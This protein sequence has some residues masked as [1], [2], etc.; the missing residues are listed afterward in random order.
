MMKLLQLPSR[1]FLRAV[2]L[3]ALLALICSGDYLTAQVLDSKGKEFWV[4]FM[5]NL[6]S[7]QGDPP[8]DLRFYLSADKPATVTITYTAT[9]VSQ[10]VTMPTANVSREVNINNLFGDYTEL[11]DVFA[12]AE[13][14]PKSYHIT[15][16]EEI[17]L[18]GINIL[19]K[20][21]DAFLGLPSDVL[22]GRYIV[23][24]YPNGWDN[25]SG[26]FDTPSQFC[27]IG[28]EDGTQ[29]R[30]TSPPGTRINRHAAATP[31]TV[32]L[33]RGQVFFGQASLNGEQ[34]VSGTEILADKPVAVFGGNKRTSIPTR[35]GNFRDHLVEQL[36]PLDAWGRSALVTPH[37][38]IT[39]GSQ[40]TAV[41]RI[42][43]AFLGTEVTITD[44]AGTSK[45]TL[46]PGN[47]IELPLM[48]PMSVDA[49]Q[50]IMVAQYEH[51][52]GTQGNLGDPFMMLVPPS[53]QF[54]TAYA[55]QSVLHSEFSNAHF[56]NVVIPSGGQ[57]S[58]ILDNRPL[59]G[60]FRPIPGSRHLYAQVR[61]SGGS[62]YIRA[63][64][65][66]GLYVYGYGEA[67]SY[68]YPGGMLFRTLV[69]DFQPPEISWEDTCG[70]V[71][72]VTFD[73]K[74]TDSGLDSVYTT[75]DTK[76]VN[77][78]IDPFEAGE[79][80][81]KY[82]AQLVDP[83][84]DGLI[85]IKAVDR[86]GRIRTQTNQIPGFTLRVAGVQNAPAV[87]D[88][89]VATN[90]Q[91]FCRQVSIRN[92]GQFEQELTGAVLAQSFPGATITTGF[93][94]KIPPGGVGNI[95]ICF[96]N[97][98]DTV[99]SVTLDISGLCVD[100]RVAIIPIDSRIDTTAPSV[101][102]DGRP[103]G[104]E[105][106][107]NY[108]EQGRASG[109]VSVE[110]D[111]LINCTAEMVTDTTAL[112][113][114]VLQLRLRR[115]N[116]RQDMIYAIR[117]RDAAGNTV[118]DR[119]TIGGFTVVVLA[120][121][122]TMDT[123]G[124][125]FD[126]DWNG[127]S[128]TMNSNECDSILLTNYGS[129]PM[130]INRIMM[131]GNRLYSVPPAQ[132]PLTIPAGGMRRVAVCIEGVEMG[133]LLDTMV[134]FDGCDHIEEV[135]MVTPV[136]SSNGEGLD[137]CN[138]AIGITTYAPTKRNFLTTPLPNPARTTATVDVAL[139]Q[140]SQVN[141]EIFDASGNPAMPVLR[142]IDLPAGINRVAFDVSKLD[143]G[144]YFCRMQTASGHVFVEKLVVT[145]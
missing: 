134:I 37:F 36:P 8:C 125:R 54:D 22:T 46:G 64:S 122:S 77:V 94:M 70:T 30:I 25:N 63:D 27:V 139:S 23:L 110:V 24:A 106:I 124:M 85:G 33:N 45:L 65:A 5:A 87:L 47:S 136:L 67:T 3:C 58:V 137:N 96:D 75:S 113:V 135:K 15:S 26:S 57:N 55:F 16:T 52:V 118:I 103:C 133:V 117:L 66:F 69:I 116:P 120:S 20:S 34:D 83:Y 98:N 48:K 89:F 7:S 6:G 121:N 38:E 109:I 79:D 1:T 2:L 92:Y 31:F 80:S 73:D 78:M 128:L 104:D 90:S 4:A 56:I 102:V 140:G 53:E 95:D 19:P 32:T 29:V 105:F 86:G 129:Q 43:A 112:P 107:V 71:R 74:I 115:E 13:V 76:N 59:N 42:L 35:V 41:V 81:V 144:A 21:A 99:F 127:D 114:E 97:M 9:G 60:N 68:G 123:L 84:E 142:G 132:F 88:T 93:P 143:N 108:Y 72:G 131:R 145:R 10:V 61:V 18:Y 11:D 138:N 12:F 44:D 40:D 49:T 14:N 39:P 111:T 141:L 82:M 101:T 62:H 50:P 17:T 91:F 28:T 119:D 100:R 51:S 130:S 126:R